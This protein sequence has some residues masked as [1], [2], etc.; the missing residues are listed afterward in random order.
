MHRVVIVA[1]ATAAR[2]AILFIVLTFIFYVASACAERV[3][4]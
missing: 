2:I 1:A 4:G 3:M